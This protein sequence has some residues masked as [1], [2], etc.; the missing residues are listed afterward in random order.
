MNVDELLNNSSK[1]TP[2][3]DAQLI[4]KYFGQLASKAKLVKGSGTSAPLSTLQCAIP[5]SISVKEATE[6][7][8]A[9]KAVFVDVRDVYE[10]EK[11]GKIPD[12]VTAPRD[13]LRSMLDR[14]SPM[15]NSL[16]GDPSKQYVLYCSNGDRSRA[17]LTT[18]QE[19][20]F[21]NVKS[22]TS[23]KDWVRERAPVQQFSRN[24]TFKLNGLGP[25]ASSA[26]PRPEW[27]GAV[28]ALFA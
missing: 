23:Y 24:A 2:A 6:L 12:A 8:Q 25:V 19:M 1:M 15:F 9:N 17:A 11:N 21:T 27:N 14:R 18:M 7:M 5:Q 4:A 26:I 13:L 28:A 16:F 3:H 22:L 20:G 10:A